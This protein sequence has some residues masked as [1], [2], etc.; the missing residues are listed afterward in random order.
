M[1]LERT[2]AQQVGDED[3][4]PEQQ[5]AEQ[6]DVRDADVR[7]ERAEEERDRR[8]TDAREVEGPFE[9]QQLRRADRLGLGHYPGSAAV[10]ARSRSASPWLNACPFRCVDGSARYA[11]ARAALFGSMS[12]PSR[13]ICRN[14]S[15]RASGATGSTMPAL[16]TRI[17]AGPTQRS[18]ASTSSCTWRSSETSAV[19]ASARPPALRMA[20]TTSSSSGALREARTTDAP[21]PASVSAT[22]R[23]SPLPPP[24]TMATWPE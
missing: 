5:R 19:C 8:A 22:A 20:F 16:F 3:R 14:S 24:V 15:E 23:P 13:S 6:H 4:L 1:A 10:T 2:G 12:R 11:T 7:E 9:T 21:S 18:V 17:V